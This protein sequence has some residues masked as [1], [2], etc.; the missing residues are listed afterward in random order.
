MSIFGKI[1]NAIFGTDAKAAPADAAPGSSGAPSAGSSPAPSGGAAAAEKVDVAK[2]LDAAAKDSGQKLNWKTSIVDLMKALD[3]DSS[4]KAR[5]SLAK[6]L[7]YT[8]DMDDSAKMN[9]WLHKQVIK[10]LEENGG[11]VPADLKD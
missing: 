5:Q 9:I 8:G 11:K 4:L 2:I 6:E 10:K 3:I 7:N 1:M